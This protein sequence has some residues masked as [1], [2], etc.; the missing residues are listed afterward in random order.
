MLFQREMV[1]PGKPA[2]PLRKSACQESVSERHLAGTVCSLHAPSH[3]PQSNVLPVVLSGGNQ[4]D[5]KQREDHY[6]AD[7]VS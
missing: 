3:S 5:R 1:T 7:S 6:T 4:I 2:A